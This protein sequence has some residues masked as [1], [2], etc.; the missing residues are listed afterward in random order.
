[1]NRRLTIK[2]F[3]EHLRKIEQRT[4]VNTDEGYAEKQER[5]NRLK[6]DYRAFVRYYLPH[7]ATSECA[8]FHAWAAN[9]LLNNELVRLILEWFRGCAK[10]VHADVAFPMFL[11]ANGQLKCMA[12]ISQNF[13][14][15]CDL[16]ADLQAELMSNQRYI[17]DFGTQYSHGNW[18]DGNFS[19]K[20]GCSF[21]ALGIGQS[22]RGLREAANRP[23]YIVVDDI[24]TQ[25][26]SNN[27]ARVRRLVDWVCDDLMGCF[28]IGNQRFIIVNNRPF[29]NTVIGSMIKEKLTGAKQVALNQLHRPVKAAKAFAYQVKDL[30]HHLRVNAVDDDFNPAWPEKYTKEYWETIRADR[31]HRS[32]MREYMNTPITEGGVIKQDWIQWKPALPLDEYDYLV[33]YTDPS[34]KATAGSDHKAVVLLGK[35]GKEIHIIKTFVRQCSVN[36]MVKYLY[37]LHES[38]DIHRKERPYKFDMK[39]PVVCDYWIEANANQDLHLESFEEEGEQRGYQLPI[40]ADHRTKPDKYSRI[41][42]ISPLYERGFIFHNSDEA[43]NPDMLR[44][45]EHKLGFELGNKIPDDELD[46]EEGGIWHLQRSVRSMNF[47]P[48]TGGRQHTNAW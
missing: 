1:M 31:S 20:D 39:A 15:A 32:W 34:W 9:E 13:D 47:Q 42:A 19:T 46:A 2:E 11:K 35:K 17:N 22:P 6:K 30:W 28:D 40:R 7:Y 12:L 26:L 23:D 14:K 4:P 41:E 5:I 8:W 18:E 44:S 43:E 16:L 27:P 24:E 37:D 38:L 48:R 36:T 10:S 25:E 45:I 33:T 29:V 3:E 21:N